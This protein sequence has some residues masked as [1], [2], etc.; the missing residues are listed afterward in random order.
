MFNRCVS[1]AGLWHGMARGFGGGRGA[2]H[3]MGGGLHGGG[4]SFR[5]GGGPFRLGRLFGQGDLRLVLL[6]LIAQKPRHGYELIKAIE[7][8]FAGAYSPSPGV[9]YPTLTLLEEE[10][11]IGGET[12]GSRR[13][14]SIT[15]EGS[16]FLDAN[17]ALV[18]AVEQRMHQLARMSSQAGPRTK[19]GADV[20]QAMRALKLV[21]VQKLGS[22]AEHAAQIVQILS[23][24]SNE[25]AK[26]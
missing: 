19:A 3:R 24:A 16:A 10:G 15:R 18:E 17:R 9:I 14:Y 22:S 21:L 8:V 13:L 25:I 5:G 6:S 2:G 11:Y 23:R 20:Q 1:D 12:Q 4:G 26:L 7:E